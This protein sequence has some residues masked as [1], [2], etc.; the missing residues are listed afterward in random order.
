MGTGH[1]TQFVYTD[2][3]YQFAGKEEGGEGRG[4][5]CTA[6]KKNKCT[7]SP[8]SLPA[9]DSLVLQAILAKLQRSLC[10]LSD[11]GLAVCLFMSDLSI[12]LLTRLGDEKSRKLMSV[13]LS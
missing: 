1:S 10:G 7:L 11:S 13:L 4:K 6:D 12:L 9:G 2:F 5:V 8:L 3:R